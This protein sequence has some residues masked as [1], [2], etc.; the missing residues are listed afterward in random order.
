MEKRG[1]I[2]NFQFLGPNKNCKPNAQWGTIGV[3][4]FPSFRV[5]IL[6]ISL[7]Y[8]WLR[9]KCGGRREICSTWAFRFLLLRPRV[10]MV[11]VASTWTHA[12]NQDRFLV[13]SSLQ[14]ASGRGVRTHPPMV[15]SV[16]H[17]ERLSRSSSWPFTRY[18]KLTFFLV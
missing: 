12:L 3:Y 13:Q 16:M 17:I 6:K 1:S 14:K 2:F 18:R 11:P 9:M 7:D 10:L 5:S 8:L 15:L 4:E